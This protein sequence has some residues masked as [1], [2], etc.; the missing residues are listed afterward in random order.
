MNQPERAPF[1]QGQLD[2]FCAAYAVLNALRLLH[3]VRPLEARR[4]LHEALRAA[5]R[6]PELFQAVLEQRTDYVGWVD[7]MLERQVQ[8]GGLRVETPFAE[9]AKP[10]V[11]AEHD[12]PPSPRPD[13]PAGGM[14]AAPS[15]PDAE[16]IWRTLAGW[17]EEGEGRCALFQ[18][19]RFPPVGRGSIRHWTCCAGVENRELVLYDCSR[20]P[21]AL[22][23]IARSR[24]IADETARAPETVLIPPHTV[25]LVRS[26]L[27]PGS[28]ESRMKTP[29]KPRSP[30]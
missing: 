1:Y 15:S 9:A 19:I 22:T 11:C 14:A 8:Q 27:A 28:R 6:D 13:E 12:A 21:G 24:L 16:T 29:E 17:L 30:R 3:G 4:L 25:R 2:V 18:F 23:R 5:A 7:A 10:A 26:R 20:E